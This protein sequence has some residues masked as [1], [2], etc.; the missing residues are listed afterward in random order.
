M[1]LGLSSGVPG[2]YDVPE[3]NNDTHFARSLNRIKE[4]RNKIQVASRRTYLTLGGC[5]PYEPGD[6]V[7]FLGSKGRIGLGCI[8]EVCGPKYRIV[9]SGTRSASDIIFT[10]KTKNEHAKRPALVQF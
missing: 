3:G 9:H 2:V 1:L 7:H 8:A 6:A 10:E 4:G 5:F